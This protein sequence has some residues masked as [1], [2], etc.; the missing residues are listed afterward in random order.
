[1]NAEIL[2]IGDEIL[3][4]LIT[5]TNSAYISRRLAQYGVAVTR[6]TKVGDQTEIIADALRASSSRA[7]L[8]IS[9][10]G[11]GPTHDDKTRDAAALF[12]DVSLQLNE[13][14]LKEIE[15][16]YLKAGRTMSAAN[17]VQ[18]M[19][20]E[21]AMYLSNER[22]TA[23]GL[24]FIKGDTA[25]FCFQGVPK[26]M[27]WMTENYLIPFVQKKPSSHVVR[28]KTIRTTGIPESNLFETLRSQVQS[29]RERLDIAFLPKLTVGVDLRFT[30]QNMTAEK[31][32]SLL[33][34][35]EQAFRQA[36][37][38]TYPHG[39]YGE[40]TISLEDVVAD[41]LF[42]H[43]LTIATA[44]SCTGGLI[45]HRLTNVPGSS[46]YFM[47]GI[48]T[49]SNA[50]KVQ[51]VGVTQTLLDEHG[52]VSEPV[53]RAMAEGMRR[54]AQTDIAIATTGIAGPTGATEAKPLGLAYVAL[55]TASGT[56]VFKHSPLPFSIERLA[57]KERL[58]QFALDRLRHYLIGL[59]E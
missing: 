46:R 32:D 13:N 47:Q 36:I 10:G 21:G 41:L 45:A 34:E 20:P 1:M 11:L 49:Y 54:V 8:V 58:S 38:S 35:A 3:L 30:V 26:E 57:F 14:A 9:C 23:P 29:Y 28:Y 19:I 6:I 39:V 56:H 17:R 37:E 15:T 42:R 16:L 2:V 44:E 50:A 12:L 31:A 22:G 40:G 53:V 33:N 5:D 25:F 59:S 43:N 48:T 51:H 7:S 52:A 18:A 55:A 24:H 27:E 4:G